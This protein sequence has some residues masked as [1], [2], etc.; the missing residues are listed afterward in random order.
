MDLKLD[1][2]EENPAMIMIIDGISTRHSV[3]AFGEQAM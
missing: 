2:K 1:D 3:P